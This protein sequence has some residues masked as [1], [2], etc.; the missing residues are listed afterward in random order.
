VNNLKCTSV[1]YIVIENLHHER[2]QLKEAEAIYFI[3]PSKKNIDK[4]M[5]DYQVPQHLKLHPAFH[6]SSS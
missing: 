4:L 1:F 5:E 3:E 6:F 2:A